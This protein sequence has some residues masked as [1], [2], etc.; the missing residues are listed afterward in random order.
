MKEDLMPFDLPQEKSNIIK[1][2]GVGGG[3]SNAVNHMFHQGIKD[4]DFIVCNTDAQALE[5]SPVPLK[6]QIGDAL[7]EGR[8]AGNKPDIG[9][10]AAIENIDDVNKVAADNA[11]MVFITA[12]M[13]GGTGTGAAPV[14]A[15]SVKELG[16][17]TV[18]IVTIPFRFEGQR[19]I[20]QAIEGITEITKHVD[21]LLVIN[22]EKLREIYGD[23]KISEAFSTADDI[24]TIA[25]KGIAEIITVTGH[26]N[27]DF[28][29]VQTVM[30]N[31]GVAL[32]GAASAEGPDRAINAI[33]EALSSPLL[34][35]NDINGA[36]NILLHITSGSGE[37]EVSMDEVGVMN[38]YLQEAAG[39]TADL[40]WGNSHDDSLGGKVHATVIATGFETDI[41]P[42]IFPEKQKKTVVNLEEKTEP[43]KKEEEFIIKENP[44]NNEETEKIDLDT[45]KDTKSRVPKNNTKA[46]SDEKET[47][48]KEETFV[49][50][51]VAE[52][53][54][55]KKIARERIENLKQ[56]FDKTKIK[57]YNPAKY[58]ENIEEFENIPA[59]V[60]KN[61][62]LEERKYSEQN[63]VSRYSLY[64]DEKQ[65]KLRNGNAYL[66][67][68][69]D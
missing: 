45:S 20:R 16:I 56:R 51:E 49:I 21:S 25:A 34:N 11:K 54:E 44:K 1:V 40:I 15:Q 33:K 69:V 4:V 28:A 27:V 14:I 37:D 23:L 46:V 13:G 32:M 31:S 12:G 50:N 5:K 7:T 2:I 29:D 26:V 57:K 17:L 35:N 3:G 52:P 38:E 10:E 62:P 53:L 67:D 9:R 39:Y 68:N 65:T 43:K 24:L 60:R 42:G 55:N 61:I 48:V 41:I 30:Q 8:G 36:K 58:S 64:Q 63:D 47:A 18:A 6:V 66:H 19:R 22:N 59:Y